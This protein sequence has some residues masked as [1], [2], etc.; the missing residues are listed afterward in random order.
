VK[1]AS[2]EDGEYGKHSP[3][4]KRWI[5]DILVVFNSGSSGKAPSGVRRAGTLIRSP[6]E[7]RNKDKDKST[8]SIRTSTSSDGDLRVSEVF[9]LVLE[10]II[11]LIYQE[12]AFMVDFLQINSLNHDTALTFADYMALDHYFRRQA[13][14][15]NSLSSAT[16]KLA[17]GAMD[18]IFGF[19]PQEIKGWLEK[20]LEKDPM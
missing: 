1:K 4:R 18:L 19:L 13:A 10:Q 7:S 14:R 16:V 12:N 17:R 9:S 20:A 15:S 11:P 2:E 8:S 6:M 3:V 5:V